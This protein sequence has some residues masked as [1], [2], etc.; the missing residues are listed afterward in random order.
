VCKLLVL[1]DDVNARSEGS[2]AQQL[3]SLHIEHAQ[4]SL[5]ASGKQEAAFFVECY[6]PRSSAT[7][8]PTLDDLADPEVD[9]KC[10]AVPQ[11]SERPFASD[12]ER[13]R[14]PR[15]TGINPL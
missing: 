14:P 3:A 7:V 4:P 12:Y 13:L 8:R 11:V 2:F 15:G 10:L 1:S 6:A 5:I 9:R